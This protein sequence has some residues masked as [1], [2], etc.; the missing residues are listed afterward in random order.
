MTRAP[1]RAVACALASVAALALALPAG[2]AA[3]VG[4]P[5]QLEDLGGGTLRASPVGPSSTLAV[6]VQRT[7]AGIEFAPA[8]TFVPAGCSSTLVVTTCATGMIATELRLE[9]T[10]LDADVQLHNVTT[11]KV[12]LTGGGGGDVL[13]VDGPI[14][15][16]TNSIGQVAL[17]PGAGNDSVTIGGLVNVI[18]LAALDPGDDRWV[19]ASSTPAGGTLALGGGND[20]ALSQAPNLALDGG[21]G[22]DVLSGA[23]G[24]AGGAGDDTLL[25]AVLGKPI[26]G[27]ADVD[28]LSYDLIS[29][30][31]T[32]VKTA[33]TDVSVNADPDFKT[34]I[35]RIEGGT[36]NDALFGTGG[37]DYLAGGEGDDVIEGR[38]GGDV[39]DGGPGL[40]TVSYATGPSPVTVDLAA[41]TGGALPLDSL[42][43][44]RRVVTGPGNDTATGSS[45]DELFSLGDGDDVLNAGAGNDTADGGAGND[46]MRGGIG[47]DVLDGGAGVDTAT[48]DERG[49]SEP[50]GVTLATLGGDGAAGENDTLQNIEN[51]TG[52][53]SNDTL[54][55]DAGPNAINGGPGVNTL[56]GGAGD[57]Q[58]VGGNDRDVIT[59]GPGNDGLYGNGD[60][61]SINA[62][63]SSKPDADIVAC[64]DSLDDDAQVDE[65]DTVSGCEFSRRA[66]VPVP[67]DLDQDGFVGG[68][69]CDDNDPARNQ[70][71]TDVP[72]DG[73][74]QDCDG[75]DTPIPFVD[76]GLSATIS[77]PT[78]TQRGIKFTRFVIT[79]LQSDRKVVVTCKSAAGKVGRCPFKT[80]TLRPKARATQVSLTALFKSRRLA[81]GVKIEFRVTAPKF[82][83]RVRRF[84][85][86]AAALRSQEL[87]LVAPRTTPRACPAGDE[88]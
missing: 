68:F 11:S 14:P 53:A 35:D 80:A 23:N 1:A 30:P 16:D 60:D 54:V 28:R 3:A 17:D 9:A 40:N 61:D 52:G 27:G 59:G 42:A 75:F 6:Q 77:K 81:P 45:A 44:F 46:L 48:Y 31:L 72:G 65:T 43:R 33:P 8:A 85:V 7:G 76:Y 20:V 18:T 57:D 22:D 47:T 87:C 49:A 86:R 36:G 64:G 38:G 82:N 62:F 26:A 84:T 37:Q 15:G 66:D 56:D 10:T 79:R 25:P 71:A 39:L 58:V 63:D 69:D 13:S 70:G 73:I 50:I 32:I 74:D 19:V 5:Y 51:V 41:G 55:G 29:T 34:G 21:N 24:L 67:V 2:A 78:R 4:P 12:T 88:L 83:G